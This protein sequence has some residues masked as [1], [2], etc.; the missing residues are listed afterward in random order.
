MSIYATLAHIGVK[1]FGDQGI[2]EVLIQAVPA[3]IDYVGP[4]WSF[5][6]PPIDPESEIPRAVCFVEPGEAKGTDRCGQEYVRP[7]LVITGT[8][9]L[10]AGFAD[11]ISRLEEALDFRYGPRPNIIILDPDGTERNVS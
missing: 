11:L 9:Y 2:T 4:A 5:L 10:A 6:P 3:H 7:L 1:R 8:E